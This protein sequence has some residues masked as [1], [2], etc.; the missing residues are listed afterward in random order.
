MDEL[1][2]DCRKI[3]DVVVMPEYNVILIDIIWLSVL[4]RIAGPGTTR[5]C[6]P[7]YGPGQ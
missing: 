3:P 7:G 2:E 5:R 4:M 1:F 6:H